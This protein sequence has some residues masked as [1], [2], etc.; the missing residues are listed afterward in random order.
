MKHLNS[1]R[2]YNNAKQMFL[3]DL[4]DVAWN[5][6]SLVANT[7]TDLIDVPNDVGGDDPFLMGNN[8]ASPTKQANQEENN[9]IGCV[10]ET[11][12]SAV[13]QEI[14]N[15]LDQHIYVSSSTYPLQW[16]REN[17]FQFP[18]I[19]I[20]ARKWLCVPGNSTPSERVFSHCGIAL[21]VKQNSMQG[22]AL[23]NQILCANE[24]NP[25]EKQFI[26]CIVHCGICTESSF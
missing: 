2:E 6:M 21:S 17:I 23:M 20:A 22:D 15:Y 1:K 7:A 4:K 16:R 24:S 5:T 8:F 18:N 11:F 26:T 25:F 19:A 13:E 12:A 3:Q 9:D 10:F 14:E